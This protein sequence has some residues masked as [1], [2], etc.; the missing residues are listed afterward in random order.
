MGGDGVLV[1]GGLGELVPAGGEEQRVGGRG[2]AKGGKDDGDAGERVYREG[3]GRRER[4]TEGQT[5]IEAR[6]KGRGDKPLASERQREEKVE[7]EERNERKRGQ[8]SETS[9]RDGRKL[10]KQ[11]KATARFAASR[12]P[13][14]PS[15]NPVSPPNRIRT[16]SYSSSP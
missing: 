8:A 5:R 9:R 10:T 16:V 13:A 11:R 1:L 12:F 6:E 2:G 3:R 14:A 4:E 15:L 7:G